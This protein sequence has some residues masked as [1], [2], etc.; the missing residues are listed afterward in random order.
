[1]DPMAQ[2]QV[3]ALE[4]E[5]CPAQPSGWVA[6]AAPNY[7]PY[8]TL[9][10]ETGRGCGRLFLLFN[11]RDHA[12]KSLRAEMDSRHA[13]LKHLVV[14]TL[15]D[16]RVSDQAV[17]RAI[18]HDT[19]ELHGWA[20]EVINGHKANPMP[21]ILDQ[22]S[23]VILLPRELVFAAPGRLAVVDENAFA[24]ERVRCVLRPR[25]LNWA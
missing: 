24:T 7:E 4:T 22:E 15:Y 9:R 19:E 12:E 13:D 6:I 18:K 11:D 2:P 16:V 3:R 5:P 8:W 20:R 14:R 21:G 23:D 10:D 25:G 1:M 17:V